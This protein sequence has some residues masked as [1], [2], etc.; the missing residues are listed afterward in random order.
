MISHWRLYQLKCSNHSHL[1]TLDL[2]GIT[3]IILRAAILDF[4]DLTTPF[5]FVS[6]LSSK[7]FAFSITKMRPGMHL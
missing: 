7:Q 6:T 2:V 5:V 3:S 1:Q 4:S